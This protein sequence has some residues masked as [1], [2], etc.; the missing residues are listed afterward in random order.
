MQISPLDVVLRSLLPHTPSQDQQT[1]AGKVSTMLGL[2]EYEYMAALLWVSTMLGLDEDE[3]M[4]ASIITNKPDHQKK[5]C[6]EAVSGWSQHVQILADVNVTL[7]E[8]LERSV[9]ESAGS[10]TNEIWLEQH[11]RETETFG[12]TVMMIPSGS[13]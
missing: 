5:S 10:F 4:P 8:V 7:H 12:A 3:Y 6:T 1:T 13:T 2:D 11:F 9:A